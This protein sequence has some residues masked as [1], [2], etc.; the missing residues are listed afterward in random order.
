MPD[1]QTPTA[2]TYALA[3]I[4]PKDLVSGFRAFGM[5]VREADDATQALEQ[6]RDLKQLTDSGQEK[7]GAVF[8]MDFLA[9]EIPPEDYRKATS[10]A[11]PS[12]IIIPGLNAD[13]QAGSQKLKQLTEQAIGFDILSDN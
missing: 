3:V 9:K 5:T 2:D 12:V 4:G 11:Y 13:K 10:G 6:I 7:Y 1:P 8:L